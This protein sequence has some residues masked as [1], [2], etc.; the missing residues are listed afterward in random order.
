MQ[1]QLPPGA[2]QTE[3]TNL[4]ETNN[5]VR[6]SLGHRVPPKLPCHL[7]ISGRDPSKGE[8]GTSPTYA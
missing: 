8:G 2:A 4:A 6:R 7:E 1:G 5:E 3:G